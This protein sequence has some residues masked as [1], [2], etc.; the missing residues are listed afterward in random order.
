[1][2]VIHNIYRLVHSNKVNLTLIT[3]VLQYPK[4]MERSVSKINYENAWSPENFAQLFGFEACQNGFTKVVGSQEYEFRKI[5]TPSELKEAQ[6]VLKNGF[7]WEDIEVPPVHILALWEDTGG[8]N[9]AAFDK[10]GSMVGYAGG[11]GGGL[12]TLTDRPIIISSMLAMN[13]LDYRSAGIGKWLKIIQAYYSKQNGYD[14]MKWLYDPE[15]GENA[16]LNMRKLGA[17]AE[18]F[19][20]DKYGRM[21]SNVFG[22][23]VPTDRFRAV[24]R[25]ASAGTIQR[26]I[27]MDEAPSLDIVKEVE[28]ATEYELPNSDKVLVEISSNID[29]VTDEGEKIEKRLRLRKILSHYFFEKDYIASEFITG[30]VK[31]KRENYY[32]LQPK[33]I[34]KGGVNV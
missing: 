33:S 1:M 25:F 5:S 18:E 27:G 13:G 4:D 3:I 8:G 28:V 29:E 15:R 31:G 9:F 24:W 19:W 6:N 2:Q 22:G 20:I 12:D 10:S 23:G 30:T 34:L 32:L 17:K 11:M 26:L 7:G 16:S 14:S 21:A